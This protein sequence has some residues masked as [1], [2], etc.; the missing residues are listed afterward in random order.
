MAD[1]A[2]YSIPQERLPK[3]TDKHFD[4]GMV[5]VPQIA[6][7]LLFLGLT[8]I[9]VSFGLTIET[10]PWGD[11]IGVTI[12]LMLAALWL[13]TISAGALASNGRMTHLGL[14]LSI[15]TSMVSSFELTRTLLP[16]MVAFA[17][18]QEYIWIF[19]VIFVVSLPV[20]AAPLSIRR[21]RETLWQ[22]VN[23]S[24]M[25]ATLYSL[26]V[27]RGAWCLAHAGNVRHDRYASVRTV[28][29]CG[30]TTK[31]DFFVVDKMLG[32]TAYAGESHEEM[33]QMLADSGYDVE[34]MDDFGRTI[35]TYEYPW[36]TFGRSRVT[37]LV[38]E[39]PPVRGIS[40]AEYYKR[41]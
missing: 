2:G 22:D 15:F 3:G 26:G 34:H 14:F 19:F 8:L 10:D 28:A 9:G 4:R 21:M 32:R 39:K 16:T 24:L 31:E 27:A 1:R 29:T 5:E 38:F 36:S 20:T 17:A 23:W 13:A 33:E 7:C 35:R 25:D 6:G 18:K 30:H 12:A 11:A 40:A 37:S 41:L